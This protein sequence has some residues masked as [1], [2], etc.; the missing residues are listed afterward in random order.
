MPHHR[1]RAVPHRDQLRQPTRL[2]HRGHNNEVSRGVNQVRQ[3]LVVLENERCVF[4]SVRVGEVVEVRLTLGVWGGSEE[5]ELSVPLDSAPH[6]ML[7]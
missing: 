1:H 7:D 3:R 5:D 2:E 6:R 4:G